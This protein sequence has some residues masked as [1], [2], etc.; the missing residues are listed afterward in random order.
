MSIVTERQC[1]EISCSEN[2][3]CS[4][5]TTQINEKAKTTFECI[6]S[7]GIRLGTKFENINNSFFFINLGNVLK[8]KEKNEIRPFNGHRIQHRI[9]GAINGA[10]RNLGIAFPF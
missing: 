2:A 1:G 9:D 5:S 4:I 3:T 6:D 8:S 7:K 10:F